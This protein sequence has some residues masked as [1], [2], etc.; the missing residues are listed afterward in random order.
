VKIKI[1]TQLNFQVR[2]GKVG[3]RNCQLASVFLI[4]NL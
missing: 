2:E 3:S 1:V 4:S